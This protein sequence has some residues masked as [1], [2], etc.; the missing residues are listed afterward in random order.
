MRGICIANST[1]LF[2]THCKVATLSQDDK[3]IITTAQLVQELKGSVSAT[4]EQKL[5]HVKQLKQLT[6]SI[7]NK[8]LLRVEDATPMKVGTPTT[9]TDATAPRVLQQINPIHQRTT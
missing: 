1:K 4:V 6:A 8:P 3:T 5:Q 7:T 2:P 9:S